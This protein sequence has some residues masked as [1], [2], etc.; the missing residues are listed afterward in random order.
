ML[1]AFTVTNFKC[2]SELTI[3]PLARVNLLAGKNN[4]G[5]TALLEALFLH[6]GYFNPSLT[7]KILTFRG[8]STF[9]MDP[10]ELWGWLFTDKNHGAPI[11]F[12]S[13]GDDGFESSLQLSLVPLGTV[14]QPLEEGANSGGELAGSSATAPGALE[15][16]YKYENSNG[17]VFS[18]VGTID[19]NGQVKFPGVVGREPTASLLCTRARFYSEDARHFDNLVRKKQYEKLM[20]LA[21]L[22]EPSLKALSTSGIWGQ[23]LILADVGLSEFIPLAFVG[24]G[25]TRFVSI[26]LRILAVPGGVLLVDEIDNGI[27]HSALPRIWKA[28]AEAAT[29]SDVQIVAT[30]H[31]E[32][33]VWAAHEAFASFLEYDLCVHRLERIEDTIN[34][35]SLDKDKMS[36]VFDARLEVR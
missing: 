34:V 8:V 3:A 32:E 17:E 31:S 36:R 15:V 33:C 26:I 25:L 12:R 6:A 13:L 10:E 11:C 22:F 5:K 9:P 21:R 1:R 2:F 18:G 27:H 19:Q 4:V 24:E 20:A 29:E 30:T 16:V 7:L 28:I 14:Q 23:Q 35:V